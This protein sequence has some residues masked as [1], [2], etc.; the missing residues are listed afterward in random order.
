LKYLTKYFFYTN[1]NHQEQEQLP[2]HSRQRW[3]F[4]GKLLG[5]CSVES[6]NI[7]GGFTLG[8]WQF[9]EFGSRA[10]LNFKQNTAA[11]KIRFLHQISPKSFI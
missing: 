9:G 10:R 8:S 7:V 1:F 6:T 11:R 3:Y 4:G 2:E 5:K